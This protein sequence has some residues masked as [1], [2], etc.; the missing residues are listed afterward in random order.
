M[1]LRWTG[2]T[3]FDCGPA[4]T[5]PKINGIGCAA[6][7]QGIRIPIIGACPVTTMLPV[8]VSRNMTERPLPTEPMHRMYGMTTGQSFPDDHGTGSRLRAF[9][10]EG[11]PRRYVDSL[12][13]LYVL[14][15]TTI[16]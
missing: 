4:C 6:N 15:Y 8:S 16:V 1:V 12:R 10:T 9:R 11:I 7:A 3:R 2:V 13:H 5:K 14:F